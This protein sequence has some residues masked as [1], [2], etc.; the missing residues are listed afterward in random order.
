MKF[1]F[2]LLTSLVV[3]IA[4]G[5]P[6]FAENKSGHKT[7][8]DASQGQ[9][10]MESKKAISKAQDCEKIRSGT[11]GSIAESAA[12]KDCQSSRDLGAG[13]GTSSGTGSG[14]MAPGQGPR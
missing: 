3:A 11:A 14:K 12:E 13:S 2:Y 6:T 9:K 10:S 4:C 7:D 8:K 5:S 1:T